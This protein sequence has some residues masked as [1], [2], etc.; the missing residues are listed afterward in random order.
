MKVNAHN[1]RRHRRHRGVLL[2]FSLLFASST[3]CFATVPINQPQAKSIENYTSP[4]HSFTIAFPKDW[5][6]DEKG[7]PY[8]DLTTIAGVRLTGPLGSE[9]VPVAISVLHYCGEGLFKSPEEFIHNK[10]NSIG[11]IDS[12]RKAVLTDIKIAKRPGKSF[13]I[14]TFKLVYLRHPV[15]PPMREGV[16][17]ELAPPYIQ[18]NLLEQ[19]LVIPATKGFFVLNY[20]APEQ[21]VGDY[22]RCFDQ[23]VESFQPQLP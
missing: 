15:Q 10:L 22:Q 23:V 16:V 17:Y 13:Q 5:T 20:C 3:A 7:H 18:V 11:R 19:F 12:D 2:V 8:G 9:G 1:P 14:K 21:R 4:D 6:K